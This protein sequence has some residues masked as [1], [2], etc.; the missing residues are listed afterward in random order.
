MLTPPPLLA[1]QIN[2]AAGEAR[3][4][5]PSQPVITT[6]SRH[7]DGADDSTAAHTCWSHSET[8]CIPSASVRSH[9]ALITTFRPNLKQGLTQV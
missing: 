6:S 8:S 5:R 9:D 3:S 1:V 4:R 7:R 2:Q